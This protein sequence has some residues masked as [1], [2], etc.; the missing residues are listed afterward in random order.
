MSKVIRYEMQWDAETHAL[1]ERAAAASGQGS[2]K[3]YVTQLVRQHA[4]EVLHAHQS[5]ELSNA[6]F[7][8]FCQACDQS[9]TLSAKLRAAART[10]D[11]EG[12]D[13]HGES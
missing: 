4:P 12:L 10:L 1:A 6:R 3:A 13:V 5:I 2:I 8:A 7:D 11:D 9:W